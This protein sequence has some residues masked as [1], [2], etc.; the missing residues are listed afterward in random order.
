MPP[1]SI[2]TVYIQQVVAAG[3]SRGLHYQPA[4]DRA[5]ITLDQRGHR[6]TA[7]QASR[8]VRALWAQT[9]DEVC[10][11]GAA[12]VPR[13]T[14]RLITLSLI[15]APDLNE[16][17]QRMIATV[18]I[19]LARSALDARYDPA[20]ARLDIDLHGT[21]ADQATRLLVELSFLLIHRFASW[22]IGQ[23]ITPLRVEFPYP[24]SEAYPAG[25]YRT[26][27]GAPPTFGAPTAALMF[28]PAH[29]RAPIVQTE[30]SLI[31]FLHHSPAGLFDALR[32][33]DA[34]APQVRRLYERGLRTGMPD[35]TAI[36]GVLAV[37]EPHLRRLL[38]RE[39]TSLTELKAEVMREAAVRRLR[40]GAP[41]DQVSASLGFS[42]PSAFRRAFKRWTGQAPGA[43]RD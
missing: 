20:I 17:L 41:V 23:P 28:D 34:L 31:D 4:L 7:D 32:R 33:P 13:G 43:Y 14:F 38:R 16:A 5:G 2:P 40:R 19:L 39:G 29:L 21:R 27:F 18:P 12:P 9:N 8:F 15:H 6:V 10:G 35:A 26:I 1:P 24:E 37:S 42:E 11:L 3:A 25:V 36:A 22:L 30:A